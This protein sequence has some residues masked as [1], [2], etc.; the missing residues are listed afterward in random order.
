LAEELP[1][2][3]LPPKHTGMLRI[4]IDEKPDTVVLRLE[5][6]LIIPW[7]EEV[8]QCWRNVFANLGARSVQVDLSA[9]R[10]VDSAGGALLIRMHEAGFRLADGAQV[11]N[12]GSYR[13]PV[14]EPN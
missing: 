5:G 4:T 9:V 11:L 12:D 2:S 7:V 14:P 1:R 8:E 10:F 3:E 6:S 13:D